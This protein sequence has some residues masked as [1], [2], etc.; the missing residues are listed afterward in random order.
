MNT[1]EE[2][3]SNFGGGVAADAPLEDWYDLVGE[4]LACAGAVEDGS[5]LKAVEFI[6][7][8]VYR[9]VPSMS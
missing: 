1:C 8:V 6:E 9:R 2:V 4:F 5:G 3:E 7:L